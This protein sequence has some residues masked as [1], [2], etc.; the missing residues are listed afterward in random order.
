MKRILQSVALALAAILA[1]QPA[2]AT[3]TCAQ[4][5]C[6]DGSSSANCCLPSSGAPMHGMPNNA[7]MLSMG[8]SGQ[9]PS[10]SAELSCVSAPCCTVSSLGAPQLAMRIK[11]GVS[12]VAV[13]TPVGEITSVSAPVRAVQTS[14]YAVTPTRA[15]YLMFQ[16]FRI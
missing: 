2:L 5:I 4:S 12:S 15:R 14:G 7:A 13:L 6:A 9:A 16:A 8:A 10:L 11:F 3:M 1:V